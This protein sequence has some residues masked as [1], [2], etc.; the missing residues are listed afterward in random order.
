MLVEG[1]GGLNVP[2]RGFETT[3]DYICAQNYPL[4][5]VTSGKLGSINHTLLSLQVCQ[6]R[7]VKIE[8]VIYNRYPLFDPVI[9]RSTQDFL[10]DY[11]ASFLPE[12][13]FDVLNQVRF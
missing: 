5:L 7:G 2:Y 3:L 10:R 9:N 8:R 6:A 4:I 12:T 11:I 13:E 1:A